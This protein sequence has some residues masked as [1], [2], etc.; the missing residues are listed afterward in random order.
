M[1]LGEKARHVTRFVA[2]AKVG[3]PQKK[4]VCCDHGGVNVSLQD[5]F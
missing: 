5:C 3:N 1:V 4:K 2:L